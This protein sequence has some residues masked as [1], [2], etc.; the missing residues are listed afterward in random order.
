MS[1]NLLR[2]KAMARAATFV[3]VSEYLTAQTCPD[4][5]RSRRPKYR[6]VAAARYILPPGRPALAEGHS[7]RSA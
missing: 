1:R 6:D 7:T 5:R 2:Y 4:C 3:D